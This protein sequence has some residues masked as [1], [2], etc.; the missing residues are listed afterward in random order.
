MESPSLR[1]FEAACGQILLPSSLWLGTEKERAPGAQGLHVILFEIRQS[2][3]EAIAQAFCRRTGV[4]LLVSDAT[5]GGLSTCPSLSSLAWKGRALHKECF[6]NSHSI[7]RVY[8]FTRNNCHT[9][10]P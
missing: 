10:I 4:L 9:L 8:K 2:Q 5:W 7:L 6:I 1:A 3:W